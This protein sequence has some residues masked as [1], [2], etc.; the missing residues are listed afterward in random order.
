[1]LISL[2]L[3]PHHYLALHENDSSTLPLMPTSM[4]MLINPNMTELPGA[5]YLETKPTTTTLT[6]TPPSKQLSSKMRSSHLA[7]EQAS[8]QNVAGQ[9]PSAFVLLLHVCRSCSKPI[10][11]ARGDNPEMAESTWRRRPPR[12]PHHPSCLPGGTGAAAGGCWGQR[13]RPQ[14]PREI[15]N[16]ARN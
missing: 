4:G 5:L 7:A 10:L 16:V 8:R 2:P 11:D 3:L 12:H 9:K 1:M 15:C 13:W 14:L 6:S